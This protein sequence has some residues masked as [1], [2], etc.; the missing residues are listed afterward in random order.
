M[1]GLCPS[2]VQNREIAL[3]VSELVDLGPATEVLKRKSSTI[4]EATAL[5]NSVSA[6]YSQ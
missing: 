2:P 6:A 1:D 5:L 3:F 4:S